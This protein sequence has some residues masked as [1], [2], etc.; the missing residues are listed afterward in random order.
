MTRREEVIQGLMKGGMSRDEAS[1]LVRELC[2]E[3]ES[4]GRREGY[5]SGYGDGMDSQM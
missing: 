4:L 5:A 2:R 1:N 3:Y